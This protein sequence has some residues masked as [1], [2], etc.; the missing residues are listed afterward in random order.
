[1]IKYCPDF[2]VITVKENQQAKGPLHIFLENGSD[3][4]LISEEKPIQ[5]FKCWQRTFEK[6]GEEAFYTGHRRKGSMGRPSES[7]LSSDKE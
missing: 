2:K 1:M 7:P 3:L 6:F 5:Y 4:A